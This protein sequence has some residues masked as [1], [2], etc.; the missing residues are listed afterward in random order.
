MAKKRQGKPPQPP[1]SAARSNKKLLLALFAI[2][3]AIATTWVLYSRHRTASAQTAAESSE[4]AV[5]FGPTI[6]NTTSAPDPAPRGMVWIPG[7]EFS[8]G[9]HDPP[10]MDEV[11]MKATLDS[12]PIHR[13]YVDGFYMDKADVTNGE[14][15]TF[16][17][18]TGYVTV[19]ERK[20]RAEDFP[21]APAENLVA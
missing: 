14:F 9:A 2:L 13:V 15:A 8:M 20:P 21:G 3:L 19:A 6:P 10:D 17:K 1:P 4:S 18:A 5:T 11:G 7:G 16:V 12:R